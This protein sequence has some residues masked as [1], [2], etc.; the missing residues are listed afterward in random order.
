MLNN[1]QLYGHDMR[2]LHVTLFGGKRHFL[3]SLQTAVMPDHLVKQM[4]P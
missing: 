3:D 2:D 1:N 4:T